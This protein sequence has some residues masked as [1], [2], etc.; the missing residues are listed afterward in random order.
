MTHLTTFGQIKQ[1]LGWLVIGIAIALTG[2]LF[3]LNHWM[4][5]HTLFNVGTV[6]MVGSLMWIAFRI[7]QRGQ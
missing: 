1:P 2:L 4:G 5:A 6:V 3:K 7:L